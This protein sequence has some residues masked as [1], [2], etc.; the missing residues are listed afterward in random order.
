GGDDDII[1]GH[2]V[3]DGQDA[4]DDLDGG[5]AVDVLMGD[6]AEVLRTGSS[7]DPRFQTLTASTIYDTNGNAL[8]SNIDRANPTGALERYTRPLNHTAT[9][10]PTYFG[11]DYIAGG[12]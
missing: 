6:N 11:S 10:D 7:I 3:A 9:T 4:G 5:S 1:G 12:A 2:N 8:I